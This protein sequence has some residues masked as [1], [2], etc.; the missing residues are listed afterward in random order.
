MCEVMIEP[1][2]YEDGDNEWNIWWKKAE[3]GKDGIK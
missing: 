2:K 1:R 3:H